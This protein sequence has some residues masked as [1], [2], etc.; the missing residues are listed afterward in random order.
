VLRDLA[1]LAVNVYNIDETRVMLLMLSS[2]KVLVSKDNTQKYRGA[3]VKQTIITAIKCISADSR[4]LN[5]IIIWLAT[6]H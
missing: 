4:F 3:R 6:T 1:I 2:V 5:P